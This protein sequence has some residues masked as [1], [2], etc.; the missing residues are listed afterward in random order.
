MLFAAVRKGAAPAASRS[1][2][3][4]TC[5]LKRTVCFP[6]KN[7]CSRIFFE[8]RIFRKRSLLSSELRTNFRCDSGKQTQELRAR[9][10]PSAALAPPRSRRQR[11]LPRRRLLHASAS[12]SPRKAYSFSCQRLDSGTVSSVSGGG[13]LCSE[14]AAAG[15]CPG[16]PCWPR[17][18]DQHRGMPPQICRPASEPP[19]L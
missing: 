14:E 13:L 18:V 9:W 16:R 17:R 10:P 12:R 4:V 1:W 7:N 3:C 11:A 2:G 19:I 6:R 15:C 5:R 8:E